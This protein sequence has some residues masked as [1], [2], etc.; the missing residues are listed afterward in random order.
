MIAYKGLGVLADALM[1]IADRDDWRLTLVGDGPALDEAMLARFRMQQVTLARRAWLSDA[2][3]EQHI[4]AC[5]VLLAPYLS[6]TQ[7]GPIA[8][9]LAY[10]KPCIVTPVSALPEQIGEGAAGWVARHTS[11]EA[12]AA[13][14]TQ[15][16][17][18]AEERAAKA[19]A[20]QNLARAAWEGGDWDWLME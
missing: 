18:G 1:R 20:A 13:A 11:S 6:A 10:G 7:S 8:Q 16:L 9:A 19:L 12:F 17:D 5:D 14:L 15:M 2:E 3:L 4:A